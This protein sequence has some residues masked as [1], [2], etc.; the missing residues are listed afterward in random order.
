M[1]PEPRVSTFRPATIGSAS[2]GDSDSA[3]TAGYAAGW[4][5][6]AKAAAE[7]ARADRDRMRAEHESRESQR[8]A[9]VTRAIAA[10][11]A[12]TEQ[13]QRRAVPVVEE[14]RRSVYEAALELAEAVL[15]REIAPGERS[16]RTLLERALDLPI[17]ASPTILRLNPDDLRHVNLL[18]ESGQ[19]IVPSGLSLVPDARLHP[20]DA[21]TEHG[22]GAL[23]ARIGTALARARDVLLG[24]AA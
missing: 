19:A 8:D 24:D 1:S 17:E 5:A 16:A 2:T 10:L 20:G 18:I 22:E 12:A 6:G 3:R 21:I 4:A 15:Q 9:E 7:S 11:T 13:W 23:D 14:A